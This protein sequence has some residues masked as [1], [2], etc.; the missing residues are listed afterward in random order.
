VQTIFPKALHWQF[1]CENIEIVSRITRSGQARLHNKPW[2]HA[3]KLT[4]LT[5]A[6]IAKSQR[7]LVKFGNSQALMMVALQLAFPR[8][9]T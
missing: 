7:G 1:V 5:R 4:I 6:A 2:Y 8:L 3:D 9:K